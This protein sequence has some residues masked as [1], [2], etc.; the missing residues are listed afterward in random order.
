[1]GTYMFS[2]EPNE[3][4]T[5]TAVAQEEGKNI[6]FEITETDLWRMLKS[7]SMWKTAKLNEVNRR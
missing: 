6:E 2:M 5:I 4:G 7:V 3:Q 1:M